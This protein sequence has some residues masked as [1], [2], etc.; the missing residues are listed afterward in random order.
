MRVGGEQEFVVCDDGFD[1]CYCVVEDREHGSEE[2]LF[3]ER[4]RGRFGRWARNAPNWVMA[5]VG[6][7]HGE[8]VGKLGGVW[9]GVSARQGFSDLLGV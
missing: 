7:V 5:G 6:A 2:P 9:V 1:E 3:L 4:V 8:E